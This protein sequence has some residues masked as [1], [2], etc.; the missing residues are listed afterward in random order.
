MAW[1]QDNGETMTTRATPSAGNDGGTAHAGGVGKS[2]AL[3]GGGPRG[4]ASRRLA[5]RPRFPWAGGG[6]RYASTGTG[7]ARK[8]AVDR[9]AVRPACSSGLP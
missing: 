5:L 1:A 9:D 2:R 4:A 7:L 6:R 8:A 3:P